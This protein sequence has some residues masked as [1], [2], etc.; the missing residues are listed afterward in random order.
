[1]GV[2]RSSKARFRIGDNRS[3]PVPLHDAF[4]VLDLIGAAGSG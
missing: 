4:C 2:E 3:E 1:M